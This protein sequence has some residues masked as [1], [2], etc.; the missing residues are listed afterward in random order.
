MT[1]RKHNKTARCYSLIILLG[2]S[3]AMLMILA[4]CGQ[5]APGTAS[6]SGN[7][8]VTPLRLSPTPSTTLSATGKVTLSA[9]SVTPNTISITLSNKTKQT[10]LFPDHLTECNV[11]L[12]QWIPRGIGSEQWQAIAPCRSEIATRLHML[13]PGKNLTVALTAP[14]NQWMPGHYRAL[15]TYFLSGTRATPR[16]VFSASF[17][18]GNFN[19][20]QRTEIVCRA[21]AGPY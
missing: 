21:T 4:S 17:Q 11:I 13:A 5:N 12:L 1:I 15:L 2:A 16:T 20:C 3:L 19:L 6:S 7:S 14:G 10:I 18:L 8:I 9:H